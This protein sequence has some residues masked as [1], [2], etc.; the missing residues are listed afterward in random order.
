MYAAGGIYKVTRRPD[1]D[2]VSRLTQTLSEAKGT[3]TADL[4]STIHVST[5]PLLMYPR[6]STQIVTPKL[7]TRSTN[8]S[9]HTARGTNTVIHM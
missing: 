5:Q 7:S 4:S 3:I 6:S 1:F 9:V 2:L 8:T